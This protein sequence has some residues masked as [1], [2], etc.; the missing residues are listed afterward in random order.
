MKIRAHILALTGI[1]AVST[2]VIPGSVDAQ[3]VVKRDTRKAKQL[4]EQAD[5][6]Y[7]QKNY[8]EA[9][10]KYAQSITFDPTNPD[11]HFWKGVAHQDLK[12]YDQAVAA[13][14]KALE[15]GYKPIDVYRIRAA[16]QYERKDFVAANADIREALKLAPNDAVLL[17]HSAEVNYELKNYG[18]AL[19]SYQKLSA[20]AP[21]NGNLHY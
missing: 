5:K 9:V 1:I 19:A 14:T 3:A 8:R 17:Q 21:V 11:G 16:I 13:L 4:R 15:L 6:A 18:D 7:R 10:D 20:K 2:F 12:E